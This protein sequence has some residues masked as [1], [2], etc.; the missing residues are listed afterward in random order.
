MYDLQ[1]LKDDACVE[2]MRVESIDVID[3]DH[4]SAT[5]SIELANKG[6]HQAFLARPN[7][8]Y[9]ILRLFNVER[10]QSCRGKP[11][12]VYRE[13]AYGYIVKLSRLECDEPYEVSHE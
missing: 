6:S 10:L 11:I 9:D 1:A 8:A 13:S 5:L 2:I 4:G 7:Q 3:N 12:V